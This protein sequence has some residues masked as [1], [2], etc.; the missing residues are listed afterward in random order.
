MGNLPQERLEIFSPPFYWTSEDYFGPIEVVYG[1]NRAIK[2]YGALFICLTTRAVH[3]G[4]ATS[5]STEEFLL[6]LRIFLELYGN[7]ASIDSNNGT[8]FVGAE[9]ELIKDVE[10]LKNKRVVTSSAG[11]SL[12]TAW[13]TLAPTLSM[14]WMLDRVRDVCEYCLLYS[15]GPSPG[16]GRSVQVS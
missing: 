16:E 12:C 11:L 3:L 2:R 6:T 10:E 9:K 14:L 4:V 7:P 13:P 1:P 8:Y 5:L 15:D